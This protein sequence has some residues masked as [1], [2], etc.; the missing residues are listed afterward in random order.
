MKKLILIGI[1]ASQLSGCALWKAYNTAPYDN[2]EYMLVTTVRTLT[3]LG[4]CDKETVDSLYYTSLEAKNFSQYLPHNDR[5]STLDSDLF[6]LVD[7]LHKRDNPSNAYCQ[8]K[9]SVIGTSAERIQQAIA[10]RPR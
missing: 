8:A 5:T 6:K 1:I 3:Q 4:K 7:E 9:L 2:N 10:K